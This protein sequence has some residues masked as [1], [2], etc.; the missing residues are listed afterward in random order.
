ML[1]SA[2]VSQAP[3]PNLLL[4]LV[5]GVGQVVVGVAMIIY[6]SRRARWRRLNFFGLALIG[7]WLAASGVTELVVSGTELLARLSSNI[8]AITAQQ[9]RSRADTVFLD[10]TLALLA[11]GVAYLLLARRWRTTPNT[12]AA[13]TSE[14]ITSPTGEAAEISSSEPE[15]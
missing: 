14:E 5:F 1:I 11:I 3:L 8:S 4:S 9:I 2:I 6:T 10:V 15:S 13:G 12:A 7:A